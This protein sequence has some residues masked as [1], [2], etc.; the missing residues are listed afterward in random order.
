MNKGLSCGILYF[1]SIDGYSLMVMKNKRISVL[2]LSLAGI[3]NI[4]P[5][6]L[7]M[8]IHRNY[9]VNLDEISELRYYPE[10]FF[11]SICGIRIPVSRRSRK[12]L[13]NSL[14]VL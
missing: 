8:R 14:D 1:Q 11:A 10:G 13:L 2:D 3:G 9:L 5:G 4:L 12:I 7:Y 6:D